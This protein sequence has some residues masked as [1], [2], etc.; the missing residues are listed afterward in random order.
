MD[1]LCPPFRHTGTFITC[2]PLL[3]SYVT[4]TANESTEVTHCRKNLFDPD[5][6]LN[7]GYV[8][9]GSGKL[10]FSGD[11]RYTDPIPAAHLVGQTLTLNY[12]PGGVNPG[13]CFYDKNDV[14][15]ASGKGIALKVPENTAY[16][17]FSL[18]KDDAA[19]GEI[20]MEIGEVSTEYDPYVSETLF[21]TPDEPLEVPAP[22]GRSH[23]FTDGTVLTVTGYSDPVAELT[24]LKKAVEQLKNG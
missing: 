9:M 6:K 16:L 14:V 22:Q 1:L 2:T 13:M 20:Q 23:F 11:Y 17:R 3:H 4:I 8:Y 19:K 5:T 7:V 24:E 10:S 12:T 21:L 15:L 18:N